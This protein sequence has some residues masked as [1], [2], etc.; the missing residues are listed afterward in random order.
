MGW[1]AWPAVGSL[2]GL[3]HVRGSNA[4]W[5]PESHCCKEEEAAGGAL[6][7]LGRGEGQRAGRA[8]RQLASP[9]GPPSPPAS[10]AF[11]FLVRMA[12]GRGAGPRAGAPSP[13]RMPSPLCM[14]SLLCMLR[15]A[16]QARTWMS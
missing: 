11:M 14:L 4:A 8:G 12:R 9:E 5:Q 6:S 2:W 7:Y 10:N 15:Y 16:P 1:G 3:G 13:P